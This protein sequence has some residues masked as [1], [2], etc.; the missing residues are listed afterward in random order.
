[1]RAG[2]E[3][4]RR[5]RR[6]HLTRVERSEVV[7]K[8]LFAAAVKV[9]GEVGYA[10]ASISRITQAAGVAQGTF[11]NHFPNRQDLL[12]QLLP[13]VGIE[14]LE[15]IRRRV[16]HVV[17]RVEKEAARFRAF[18]DFL[19]EMPEFMRILN[20][21]DLFAPKGYAQ[22]IEII[23]KD[24]VRALEKEQVG[25][26][27]FSPEELEVVVHIMMGARSYLSH[28]FSYTNGK[29]HLPPQRVFTAYQKLFTIGLFA[30][31]RTHPLPMAKRRKATALKKARGD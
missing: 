7:K 6:L 19:I 23:S 24:Y 14:M 2:Q 25:Y 3:R 29:V 27:T 10:E 1:V 8:R 30:T 9:V 17:S 4:V 31:G 22:H 18:F 21:S 15:F 26:G 28:H 11:Y 12:D 20:E 5:S 16:R 13:A